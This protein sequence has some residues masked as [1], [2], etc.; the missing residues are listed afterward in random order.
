MTSSAEQLIPFSQFEQLRA[1]REIIRQEAEALLGLSRNLDASF[2][3][4]V[5]LIRRC[6]GSVIVCGIGKAGLIGKKI[7]ATFSSTGTRSHFLHPAEAVHGDLGC[8]D[9]SDL[10][11]MLSNS[12]ET[13]EILSVIPLAKRF[14]IPIISMTATRTNS[15]ANHS[16]VVLEIGRM[17]EACRWGLAPSTS[18]TVMLALGDALA[19]VVSEAKGFMPHDF[20]LFHPGGSLGQ[21]LKPVVEIMRPR[22]QLRLASDAESVRDVLA[23]AAKPGRR[24]GA[25]LLVNSEGALTG[26][27]TDSDLARLLETRQD[28]ALDSPISTVMTTQPLTVQADALFGDV[29]DVLATRKISELPVIDDHRRPV[30][31]ID[32]TD[33]IAWLPTEP[34]AAGKQRESGA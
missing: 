27:F 19:L 26:L 23:R 5:G 18:T 20:A 25:V 1:G 3:S 30:G 8:L 28:A 2:L 10:L 22:E 32:I 9:R 16:E 33:V 4:A 34:A 12:G 6:R 14:N 11:L 15:L 29:V 13:E 24:T 21:K 31:L 7:T 17:R